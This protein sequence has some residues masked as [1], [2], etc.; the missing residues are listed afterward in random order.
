MGW[1]LFFFLYTLEGIDARAG[2]VGEGGFGSLDHDTNY[3]PR[4]ERHLKIHGA[5]ED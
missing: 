5:S 2:A 3:L 4:P 1:Q